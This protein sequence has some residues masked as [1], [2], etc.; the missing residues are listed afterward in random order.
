MFLSYAIKRKVVIIIVVIFLYFF[1]CLFLL[2]HRVRNIYIFF[3]PENGR[4]AVDSCTGVGADFCYQQYSSS[5]NCSIIY[6]NMMMTA[7]MVL[8][9]ILQSSEQ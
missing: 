7:I 5:V 4:M 3:W 1:V 6:A 2:F 9:Y 8:F